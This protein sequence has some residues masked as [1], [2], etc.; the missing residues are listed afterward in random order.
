MKRNHVVYGLVKR[1]PL[2]FLPNQIKIFSH[3]HR[4]LK[5]KIT[6]LYSI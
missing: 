4:L 3:R 1:Y 2:V 5:V 6:S